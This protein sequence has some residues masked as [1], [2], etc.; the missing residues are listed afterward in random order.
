MAADNIYV[1]AAGA[2]TT[3]ADVTH[4]L[5]VDGSTATLQDGSILQESDSGKVVVI[6][7]WPR[8]KRR[9]TLSWGAEDSNAAY[10]ENLFD[11]NGRKYPFLFVPPRTADYTVGA[12][13]AGHWFASGDGVTETFQL[14]RGILTLDA[15][16]NAVRAATIDVHYPIDDDFFE[17]TIDAVPTTA[18]T[19]GAGGLVTFDDPPPTAA[20]IK[21]TFHFAT[22]VRF[23]SETIDVTMRVADLHEVRSVTIEEDFE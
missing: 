17:I 15:D 18:F 8:R 4:R 3:V 21:A 14:N 22:P 19:L 1:I 6:D 9:W 11:V 12:P 13:S 20:V 16:D 7:R 10:I 2:L 23:I 5:V